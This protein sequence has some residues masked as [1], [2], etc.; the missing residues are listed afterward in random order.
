MSPRSPLWSLTPARAFLAVWLLLTACGAAEA[1]PSRQTPSPPRATPSASAAPATATVTRLGSTSPVDLVWQ[2]RSA[3]QRSGRPFALALDAQGFIYVAMRRP[4]HIQK[5]DREGRFVTMWGTPGS[6]AGQFTFSRDGGPTSD[7]SDG[8][9]VGG[10]AADARGNVYVADGNHR[11][12]KFDHQGAW[13]MSW[14][15]GGT[16]DGQFRDPFGVAVDQHGDVYVADTFNHR[17]QKFDPQGRFLAAWGEQ[18]MADGQF[19]RPLALALD[20]QGH[21]YVADARQRVQKLDRDGRP[22]ATWG[23]W[24]AGPGLFAG[25]VS[26][27]VDRQG[28]V[29]V[30]DN[31]NHRVQLFDSDGGYLG[32][33]G[34]QGTGEGQ[35]EHVG[36]I[37]VD[38]ERAIYVVSMGDERLQKFRLRPTWSPQARGTPTPRPATPTATVP[39]LPRLTPTDR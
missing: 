5:F 18:G 36:G 19:T 35:F 31:R 26:L 23:G 4:D 11:V 16:G 34:S 8:G 14:G 10:I 22:L 9:Y 20:H 37:G 3:P 6:G 13:L 24:G 2:T 27:A 25:F 30:A 17:I 7:T 33:W 32:Q 15:S 21:I 39:V 38:E 29:Y 1:R 12:Q 28:I